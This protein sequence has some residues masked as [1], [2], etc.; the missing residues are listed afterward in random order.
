MYT[1]RL[2]MFQKRFILYISIFLI[3]QAVSGQSSLEE[4]AGKY[5]YPLEIKDGKLR[6]PGA[7]LLLFE[8]TRS[9]F[10]MIGEDPGIAEI[11]DFSTAIY[12]H[13][14]NIGLRFTHF[15]IET[16]PVQAQRLENIAIDAAA[17]TL[18]KDFFEKNPGETPFYTLKE[19]ANLLKEVMAIAETN[20]EILWGLDID[21]DK[22]SRYVLNELLIEAPDEPTI[23]LL[24]RELRNAERAYAKFKT[25]Q[26]RQQL[27]LYSIKEG[28][29]TQLEENF[30]DD[31]IALQMI[32]ALKAA[33]N[34]W[35]KLAA[36][37]TR[38]ALNNQKSLDAGAVQILLR[39]CF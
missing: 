35:T 32:K 22:I 18:L 38:E 16:G 31:P 11:P 29:F 23:K 12:R 36:L 19:E 24:E 30:Q 7:E 39:L 3:Y 25:T 26:D 37:E 10:F 33:K 1:V 27:Y 14:Y 20:E 5:A 8:A 28:L 34:Y 9:D 21:T 2:F 13:A 15:A 4:L 17:A 6:G